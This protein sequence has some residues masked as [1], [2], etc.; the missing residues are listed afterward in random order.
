[1]L[2]TSDGTTSVV[3]APGWSGTSWFWAPLLAAA[4][5]AAVWWFGLRGP[6]VPAQMYISDLFHSHGWV[7]W[8]NGWY[9][10]HSPF[11]YSVLFPVLGASIGL[12]GAALLCAATSA[13]AFERLIVTEAGRRNA[14]VVIL[15]AVGTIVPVAI[16][17]LPFLAGE[18]AGLLALLA[19]RRP[20]RVAAVLLAVSCAL[21]SEVAGVFLVLAVVAW[22]LTSPRE[23]RRRLFALAAV[24]ALPVIVL[25]V[26]LPRLGPFPFWGPDL[27]VVVGVC[28]IA[29][30]ALP[31]Q[32]RALRVGLA[33]YAVA[34]TVVFVIPNPLGGNIGRLAAYFAPPLIAS[35]ATIPGRRVIAV[36][37]V[38]LL[39]WQYVPALS[40]LQSDA[41]ATAGYYAPLISY[42]THQ[43]TIGRV[44]IPFTL[45]HWEA[46]Y[47]AP[48]VPLAR[49]WVRQLDTLDNPIFYAHTP[50]NA[51][52]YH[53][54]LI[55]SG[56]TW[57]ALPDVPLDYSAVEEANLLAQ[58]Q[59]YL[60]LVWHNAYWRLWN[61]TDSPGLISGPAR[62]T[63][64]EPSRVG[65]DAT[66]TGTAVLRIRY[67]PT[68]NVNSGAAC[69]ESATGGWTQIV[70][71]HPGPLQLT[72]ALLHRQSDCDTASPPP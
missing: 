25:S 16:G 22:A 54:W 34:A 46:A 23:P 41:S 26:A 55:N 7:L 53:E 36:L 50:P 69:V 49:G 57:I 38:P 33:L 30:V 43:P 17:Q 71:H 19:A 64:L 8:D 20:H 45:R 47:V 66:S 72:T 39:A 6:D 37:V 9:G 21:F 11:S 29:A 2:V 24:A 52:T 31:T 68:W 32:Y 60:H 65:L 56:I 14:V 15:F 35:F 4:G 10:G 63:A 18:A 70:I 61:V 5:V 28:L 48:R 62:V 12:Y 40:S 44:E 51:T 67:T 13:W 59:P 27:V 1:M 42:L 58:G 3:R